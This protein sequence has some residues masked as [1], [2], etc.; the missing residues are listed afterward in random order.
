MPTDRRNF[1]RQLSAGAGIMS[2]PGMLPSLTLQYPESNLKIPV[3]VSSLQKA[4]GDSH[5]GLQLDTE[6]SPVR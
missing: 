3:R 5:V 4:C 2:I 6:A 1:I